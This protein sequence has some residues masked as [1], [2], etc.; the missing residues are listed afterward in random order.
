MNR[1]VM[2][3]AGQ[4]AEKLIFGEN[5]QTSGCSDDLRKATAYVS[6]VVR[7]WG[8]STF[9]SNIGSADRCPDSNNE[10]DQTNSIIESMVMQSSK[11]A[12]EILKK[13]KKVL[14]ETVDALINVDRLDPEDFK[15]ICDNN[16]I[17]VELSTSSEEIIYYDFCKKFEEYKLKNNC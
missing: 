12:S 15:K 16:G 6:F 14:I 1:V 5:N 7:K 3:L 8:M 4:E 17:T 13:Y 9:Y 11:K 10:V 2:L